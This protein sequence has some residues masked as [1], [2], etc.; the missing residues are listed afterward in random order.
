MEK[1]VRYYYD[2]DGMDVLN[3]II[4]I[5]E[6]LEDFEL[7]IEE[8]DGDDGYEE[9]KIRHKKHKSGEALLPN[10]ICFNGI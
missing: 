8:M 10:D 5:G 6:A 1:I 4:E 3:V 2:N 9:F 7:E